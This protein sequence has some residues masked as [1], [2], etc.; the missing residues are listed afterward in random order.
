MRKSKL[1]TLS[2]LLPLVISMTGGL[3][4]P[5]SALELSAAQLADR[6]YDALRQG[7]LP[8]AQEAINQLFSCN[9]RGIRING[10]VYTVT[11]LQT[12]INRLARGED[13]PLLPRP[14]GA[15]VFLTESG[16]AEGASCGPPAPNETQFFPTGSLGTP[17]S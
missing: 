4:S 8:I 14:T 1:K 10:E 2:K 9:V 7:H 5:A 13:A 6:I 16:L 17:L 12:T 3:S 15:A 11:E